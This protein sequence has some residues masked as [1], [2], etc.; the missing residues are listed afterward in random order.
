VIRAAAASVTI[1]RMLTQLSNQMADAV[2]AVAPSVVQVQGRR[3]P[4]SGLV[5]AEHI[6]VTTMRAIGGEDGVR[7][8]QH[9]GRTHDAEL[10]GWDPATTLAV[11]RVGGLSAA[12][13]KP[14]PEAPRVGHFALA[15]ARS[16]SNA[17]TASAGI[18][19]VIGGPLQTGRRRRIEQV[20]RT[21]APMH[22]GFSG[23][24]LVD[25]AGGFL[26]V[27]TATAIRGLGVVIPAAIAWA[28]ADR[29]LQHGPTRRG[30][31]GVMGQPAALAG[32]QA[33]ASRRESGVLV[34]GVAPGSAAAEAG[35]LLGDIVL[36]LDEALTASP[37][38]LLDVLAARRAGHRATLHLLRGGATLDLPVTIG[39]S[40]AR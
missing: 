22:D 25:A 7:V 26:G 30:Y 4:A 39:E 12:P 5:Y 29:A 27:T 14:S 13:L 19:A 36:G 34:I 6:V 28:A 40:P 11:L 21:S 9:D 2:E 32:A 10:A 1:G 16:W 23:G 33:E 17:V 35:V 15:V 31:L 38:D 8:R 20:I 37:E 18:I 24:A 3:R